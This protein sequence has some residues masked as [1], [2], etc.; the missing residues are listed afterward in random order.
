MHSFSGRVKISIFGAVALWIF[1]RSVFAMS[2]LPAGHA[3]PVPAS[4]TTSSVR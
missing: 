3:G 1:A 2:P 4:A